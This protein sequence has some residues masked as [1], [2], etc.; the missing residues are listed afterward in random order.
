M[1]YVLALCNGAQVNLDLGLCQDIGGCGHV[2]EEICNSTQLAQCHQLSPHGTPFSAVK[3]GED[4]LS[5]PCTV[6]FAPN[7]DIAP[8]VPT[9]K[10]WKTLFP[11]SPPRD[12]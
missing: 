12:L 3:L 6:A 8:I 1:T 11:V 5:I 9:M 4:Q 2:D 7:A 10:Y